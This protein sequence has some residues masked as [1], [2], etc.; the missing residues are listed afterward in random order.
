MRARQLDETER[1]AVE[2]VLARIEELAVDLAA[3]ADADIRV[4]KAGGGRFPVITFRGYGLLPQTSPVG[5][6]PDMP[7]A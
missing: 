4:E 6:D 1:A 7:P 2:D 5:T 3:E